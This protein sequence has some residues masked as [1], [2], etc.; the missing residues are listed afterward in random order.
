M[1]DD[2]ELQDEFNKAFMKSTLCDCPEMHQVASQSRYLF[3]GQ[4]HLDETRKYLGLPVTE[5]VSLSDVNFPVIVIIESLKSNMV[6]QRMSYEMDPA[7]WQEAS[8]VD[9]ED[10]FRRSRDVDWSTWRVAEE[11]CNGKKA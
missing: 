8:N 3:L 4:D 7:I 5:W 1:P 9:L 11:L 10:L 6:I 2:R